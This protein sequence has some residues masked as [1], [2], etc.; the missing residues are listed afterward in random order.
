[1]NKK[2]ATLN[3]PAIWVAI[4]TDLMSTRVYRSFPY[5][6]NGL[7]REATPL[8]PVTRYAK[9]FTKG[10]L[11]FSLCL[12]SDE[13]DEANITDYFTKI[14]KKLTVSQISMA[15]VK[16]SGTSFMY[17]ENEKYGGAK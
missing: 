12:F 15:L 2:V 5:E 10:K 1:M 13:Q 4:P 9:N 3:V 11:N 14:V 16:S 8:A 7:M 17:I 6:H